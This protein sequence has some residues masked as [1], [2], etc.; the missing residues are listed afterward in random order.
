[1]HAYN[2]VSELIEIIPTL[3]IIYTCTIQFRIEDN[4]AIHHPKRRR[5]QFSEALQNLM[6]KFPT[7]SA[8]DLGQECSDQHINDIYMELKNWELVANH[9]GLKSNQIEDIKSNSSAQLKRLHTLQ[10]WKSNE[11]I[12]G[13]ATYQ[14]LLEALLKSECNE[15]AIRVCHLLV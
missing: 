14:V 11:C 8:K 4:E 13:F 2:R 7:L 15:L 3:L 1:M 6:Q 12:T 10:K 5:L 9:L